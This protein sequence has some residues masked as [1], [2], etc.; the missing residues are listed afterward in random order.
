M[1]TRMMT[2]IATFAALMLIGCDEDGTPM[3]FYSS[4]ELDTMCLDLLAEMDAR[5]VTV[6]QEEACSFNAAVETYDNRGGQSDCETAFQNC[7]AN[8]PEERDDEEWCNTNYNRIGFYDCEATAAEFEA[9]LLDTADEFRHAMK[10]ITCETLK[11]HDVQTIMWSWVMPPASCF[12]FAEECP[13]WADS[14]QL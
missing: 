1:K 7:M 3:E 14:T 4:S 9:C 13:N 10:T 5:Y 12:Q 11:R 8:P 6:T 2:I